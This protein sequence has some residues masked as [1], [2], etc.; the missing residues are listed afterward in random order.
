M[1]HRYT[2]HSSGLSDAAAAARFRPA[3]LLR[4]ATLSLGLAAAGQAQ[5]QDIIIKNDKSE[6]S[7][8]VV[9]ITDEHIKYRLFDFQDG[10][11]YNVRKAEVWMIIYEKGRREKFN[12]A[13]T[14]AAA[15]TA[16]PA[17]PAVASPAPAAAPPA[18]A[19][20][21]AAAA[22]AA[23]SVAPA[24]EPVAAAPVVAAA[25]A[26][27]ASSAATASLP[28]PV[29]ESQPV[30]AAETTAAPA[31]GPAAVAT[32][33]AAPAE[34]APAVAAAEPVAPAPVAPAPAAAAA[35][36][37]PFKWT[38]AAA[39]D[40]APGQEVWTRLGNG[41]APQKYVSPDG[42]LLILKADFVMCLDKSSGKQLWMTK[43]EKTKTANL[44]G[45]SPLLQ[46]QAAPAE[47]PQSV[48]LNALTGQV[49]YKPQAGTAV[50]TRVV[51]AANVVV[52]EAADAGTRALVLNRH[53]GA[54]VAEV[55]I[56][57]GRAAAL[58][59]LP[60]AD[61]RLAIVS[62]FGV[63]V[64]D[65][66]TGQLLHNVALKRSYKVSELLPPTEPSFEVF[67]AGLSGQVC[68]LKDGYLTSVN[69]K[70]GQITGERELLSP[71]VMYRN[72][73]KD[74]L[75]IGKS[76]R[77]DKELA[78][79]VYNKNTCQEV[80][81]TVLEI[82]NAGA[83]EVVGNS[84][85]LVSDASAVKQLELSTLKVKAERSLKAS[86]GDCGLLFTTAAGVGMLNASVVDFFNAQTFASTGRTK[87]YDPAGKSRLKVG[88]EV[89]FYAKGYVGRVNM[90]K[91][92]E[93]LYLK[94][95]LPIKLL[96]DEVVELEVHDDGIAVLGAQSMAKIDLNGKV[97]YN[98]YFAPPTLK[99]GAIVGNTGAA[100]PDVP[101]ASADK[102]PARRPARQTWSAVQR[103][104]EVGGPEVGPAAGKA[105]A[106]QYHLILTKADKEQPGRFKVVK[107]NK[108]TGKIEGQAEVE[109][110]TPDYVFDPIE[111]VVY[112]FDVDSVR[113]YKI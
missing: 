52:W 33:D 1:L 54:R 39:V 21:P 22:P 88:D 77:K 28:A 81:S 31:A 49:V 96:D 113:A 59:V 99:V 70:T 62:G 65:A 98:Q 24:A 74:Q 5:A 32:P 95:K 64:L 10:P 102:A 57:D 51:A 29:A 14:A 38:R 3:R 87:Y 25:A 19:A 82:E 55:R 109:N 15:A 91:G 34:P 86:S 68:V 100:T 13:E 8:K 7:T 48:I 80:K 72:A 79:S 36:A 66:A 50:D 97:V 45:T 12:V 47:G 108:A 104:F 46:V 18:V 37:K 53:N 84:L 40:T 30:V 112:F 105:T 101:A 75:V 6:L 2:S 58:K 43:V 85:F 83:M 26:P 11:I 90:M 35:P 89:Y 67:E 20:A 60:L 17:V 111:S 110:R 44:L 78:L 73:G 16:A 4:A 94:N 93:K 61:H 69:L 106:Q 9:E 63:S 41:P 76:Q 42:N 71:V 92:E 107:V 56:A 27:D 103:S 23:E